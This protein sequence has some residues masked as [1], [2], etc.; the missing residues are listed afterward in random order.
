MKNII[1]NVGS[2]LTFTFSSMDI[3]EE[4]PKEAVK[5]KLDKDR[6]FELELFSQPEMRSLR[7]KFRQNL[8]RR[9]VSASNKE[10]DRIFDQVMKKVAGKI[11][12]DFEKVGVGHVIGEDRHYGDGRDSQ[13]WFYVVKWPTGRKIRERFGFEDADF[14]VTLAMTGNGVDNIRKDETTLLDDKGLDYREDGLTK[15]FVNE[16]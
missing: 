4:V 7:T 16:E 3:P 5:R 10:F 2:R 13:E 9:G 12:K 6:V 15:L 1:P 8:S 14:H 11:E